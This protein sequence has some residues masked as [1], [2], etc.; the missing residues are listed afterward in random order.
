MSNDPI[1]LAVLISG[2]GR[3]LLNLHRCIAEGTL[4]A[5]IEVV[6]SSR[7]DVPGVERARQADLRTVVVDRKTLRAAE[8]DRAIEQAVEGDP[9]YFKYDEDAPA[10]VAASG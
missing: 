9:E 1:R 8:F 6:V 5:S 7:G 4:H 10:I 2:G 3:T